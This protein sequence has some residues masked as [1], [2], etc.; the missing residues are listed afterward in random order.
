MKARRIIP[1]FLIA[2]CAQARSLLGLSIDYRR[3]P[4]VHHDP[5]PFADTADASS[6]IPAKNDFG[7]M[8]H[9]ES[10]F[11]LLKNLELGYRIGAGAYLLDRN[12]SGALET[13]ILLEPG[14][15]FANGVRGLIIVAPTWSARLYPNTV[16]YGTAGD[17]GPVDAR[18]HFAFYLDGGLEYGAG[19]Q[20]GRIQML[21]EGIVARFN[22]V[23]VRAEFQL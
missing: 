13:S 3:I 12:L 16:P 1:I 19:F 21:V 17:A 11:S 4:A 18:R 9:F 22:Y 2:A 8:G 14:Y 20:A 6:P 10:L 7:A 23:R 5:S 15:G